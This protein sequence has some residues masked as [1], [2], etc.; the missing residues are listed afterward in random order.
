M[1]SLGYYLLLTAFVV[2]AYA[3]AISVAG[4]RRRSR[5]LVRAA[6]ARST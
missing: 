6:P 4:A 1:S 3:A 2:C 5:A